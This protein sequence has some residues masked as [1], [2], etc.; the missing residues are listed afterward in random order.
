MTFKTEAFCLLVSVPQLKIL[1]KFT[2]Y[3]VR[4]GVCN[5]FLTFAQYTVIHTHTSVSLPA[6]LVSALR[7]RRFQ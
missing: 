4:I 2:Q 7:I 6:I 5:R 1:R 3:L